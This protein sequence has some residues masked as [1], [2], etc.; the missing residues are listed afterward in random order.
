VPEPNR[1]RIFHEEYGSP[2][3]PAVVMNIPPEPPPLTKGNALHQ[4]L[5]LPADAVL[6]LYQGLIAETRCVLELQRAVASLPRRFHLVLI[7]VG[8][9][10][11]LAQLRAEA[12]S[13][14]GRIH[15]IPWMNAEDLHAMTTSANVG[16]LLYRNRGRNNYYAA[17]N[18]LYEYMFA[19][20]PVVSSNFPGLQAAV[21]TGGYGVCAD[22]EN[23]AE[24]AQAIL[25][26]AEIPAGTE[27]ARRAR[28][29]WSWDQQADILRKVYHA[30][31]E[32]THAE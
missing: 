30:V 22:P 4:R 21:E 26:S 7:G 15:L 18:K 1:A 16:V 28:A 9:D 14:S 20:L 17:P 32:R 23:P 11:Y 5:G 2:V 6:V 24:I 3:L 8:E 13:A 31:M 25:A 19:G 29:Q 12:G 10:A 27:I